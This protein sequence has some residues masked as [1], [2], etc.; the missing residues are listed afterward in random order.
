MKIHGSNQPK[1]NPYQKQLQQYTQTRT[2]KQVK[3]D[4]LHISDQAKKMQE[5]N[6]IDPARKQRVDAIKADVESGVYKVDA[7]Q[8]AKGLLSFWKN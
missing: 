6:G 8:V 3:A 2:E 7:E 1:V 5:L 4:Q